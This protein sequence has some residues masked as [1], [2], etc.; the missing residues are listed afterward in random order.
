MDCQMPRMDGFEATRAIRAAEAA[1]GRAGEVERTPIVALTANAMQGDREA[2]LAA[3]MDGYLAKPFTRE[4]LLRTLHRWLPERAPE[5]A[6]IDPAALAAIRQLDAERGGAIVER[7]LRSYL[8]TTPGKLAALRRAADSGDAAGVRDA[9]HA[10]KS[11]SAQLGARSLAELAK[12]LEALGRAGELRAAPALVE[13][14]FA[15]F[16]RVRRAIGPEPGSEPR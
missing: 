13:R 10:L 8:D 4:E 9:A 5:P 12:E 1:R 3:G 15:E 14:T 11:S 7:V 6:P 16:E 2:C